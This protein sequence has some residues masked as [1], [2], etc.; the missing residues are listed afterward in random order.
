MQVVDVR[1]V[2]AISVFRDMVNKLRVMTVSKCCLC[3]RKASLASSCVLSITLRLVTCTVLP[4]AFPLSAPEVPPTTMC[5]IPEPRSKPAHVNVASIIGYQHEPVMIPHSRALLLELLPP[6]FE[7]SGDSCSKCP[8]GSY[9]SVED[10]GEVCLA[11]PSR[12]TTLQTGRWLK[13]QCICDTNYYDT[14]VSTNVVPPPPPS[15][16]LYLLSS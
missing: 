11:C 6:S 14:Q 12:S 9:R 10:D 16:S 1:D 7:G 5:V 15:R 4:V 2:R 13:S 3:A 8:L